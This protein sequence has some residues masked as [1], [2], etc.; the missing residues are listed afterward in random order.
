MAGISLELISELPMTDQTFDTKFDTFKADGPMEENI[1]LNHYFK[2]PDNLPENST[3]KQVYFKPP[4]AVY[5]SENKWIYRWI[6]HEP[7]HET[8]F[9]TAI[10][11][12]EHTV[13]D[14][15]NDQDMKKKFQQ[16]GLTSLTMFP[17]DQI[18]MGRVLA[19]KNG[20]IIH[21]LGISMD[22]QGLLFVGHSS[23]GKSTMAGIMKQGATILC[24]DRNIIRKTN[25]TYTLSGTW[26]HGDVC[27]VS[28]KTVPLKAI[29]FLEKSDKNQ[30]LPI[31]DAYA[32]FERLLACLIKPLETQDWWDKS[33]NFLSS[34]CQNI[35]CYILR[36]NKSDQTY[37]FIKKSFQ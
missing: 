5:Q 19:H 9:R 14:I 27:D 25:N 15:Y 23:A 21:S 34:V 35:P 4:W 11:N 6:N 3:Q 32:S 12:T 29:L 30:I 2:K 1:I 28:S 10:A 31:K 20:C 16:G 33:L 8:Y 22:N 37:Q 26:S 36:S 18:L 17:T 13:L 7:P 24:D